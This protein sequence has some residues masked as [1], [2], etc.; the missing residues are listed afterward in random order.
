MKYFLLIS[1]PWFFSFSYAQKD[2]YHKSKSDTIQKYG[3]IDSLPFIEG[4]WLEHP[5]IPSDVIVKHSFESDTNFTCIQKNSKY[6]AIEYYKDC[7]MK[8]ELELGVKLGVDSIYIHADPS[9]P[10]SP[11]I[12]N[13]DQR[14][15]SVRNGTYKEWFQNGKMRTIGC[16]KTGEKTG[17]WMYFD[18]LGNLIRE[19]NWV[20]SI[21]LGQNADS[22]KSYKNDGL[23]GEHSM[24]ETTS[25]DSV[26]IVGCW[27]S[28]DNRKDTLI[29]NADGSFTLKLKGTYFGK[30][31]I[32][33]NNSTS[34]L[35][36]LKQMINSKGNKCSLGELKCYYIS[37]KK[38]IEACFADSNL[39]PCHFYRQ[40]EQ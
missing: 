19:E 26:S 31:K 33:K 3:Q 28:I 11:I 40:S 1:L 36:T 14:F 4:E 20:L 35:I 34:S 37:S 10:H 2:L 21:G 13:L 8:S 25:V 29:L 17:K 32:H 12:L 23:I 39:V 18:E 24:K 27:V 7:K 6:F 30:W 16:Y 9:D 38:C 15:V 22:A 5:I